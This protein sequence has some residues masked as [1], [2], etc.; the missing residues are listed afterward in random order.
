MTQRSTGDI[1]MSNNDLERVKEDLATMKRALAP[2]LRFRRTSVR[3]PLAIAVGGVLCLLWTLLPFQFSKP[4]SALA[5]LMVLNL[6]L[7]VVVLH[8]AVTYKG[9]LSVSPG[10]LKRAHMNYVPYVVAALSVPFLI[11]GARF[12]LISV[13]LAGVAFVFF[14]GVAIAAVAVTE[15]NQRHLLGISVSL[16]LYAIAALTLQLPKEVL[17]GILFVVGGLTGAVKSVQLR[18]HGTD[19]GAH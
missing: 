17:L 5:P 14:F 8:F 19:H 11:L 13:T 10:E 3:F 15:Q 18:R 1:D 2:G 9:D 4:W 7:L 16:I 6:P 12:G